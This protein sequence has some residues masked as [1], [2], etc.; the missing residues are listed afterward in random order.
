[1]SFESFY[2]LDS[3]PYFLIRER[4]IN[5]MIII[6]REFGISNII[7]VDKGGYIGPMEVGG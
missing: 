4:L 1:M 2:I 7:P 3:I 6:S 5:G